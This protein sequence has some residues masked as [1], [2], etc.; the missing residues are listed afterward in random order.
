[1]FRL[2]EGAVCESSVYSTGSTQVENRKS[3]R[4]V[5]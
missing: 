3:S 1:M 5:D 4:I 2:S